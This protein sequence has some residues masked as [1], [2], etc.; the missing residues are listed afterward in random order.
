[1]TMSSQDKPPFPPVGDAAR[2]YPGK[3]M[4]RPTDALRP[5]LHL[6]RLLAADRSRPPRRGW[7]AFA[8]FRSKPVRACVVPRD[9]S[10]RQTFERRRRCAPTPMNSWL[11]PVCRDRQVCSF[12]ATRASSATSSIRFLFIYCRDENGA[13][14]ALIYEVRNTFGER[15]TYVCPVEDGQ[16]SEAGLRQERTKI[17]YVSP[18]IDLGA[19]YHFRMLPARRHGAHAHS[20][21]RERKA[22][23]LC[24]IFRPSAKALTLRKPACIARPPAF[25]DDE[26]DGRHPLGSAEA[27]AQG[28][29]VPLARKTARTPQAMA[30][31]KTRWNRPNNPNTLG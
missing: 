24:H 1:M 13:L 25:H 3:V 28:R 6:S 14:S 31:R 22:T 29:E 23:T 16:M 18:F 9:R 10:P 19:R 17:F 27:L 2:L 15:H 8:Y 11:T 4:H 20:R 21:N 7:P 5:S 26:G 30:T 12:C